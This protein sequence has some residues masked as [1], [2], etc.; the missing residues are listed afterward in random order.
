MQALLAS[1]V[2]ATPASESV[3]VTASEEETGEAA[4]PA[5]PQ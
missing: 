2:V 1:K 5:A 3:E 4:A